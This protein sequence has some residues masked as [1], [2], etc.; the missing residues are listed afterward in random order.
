VDRLERFLHVVGV[1]AYEWVSTDLGAVHRFCF[2]LI[3]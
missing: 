3:E 2:D 1:D